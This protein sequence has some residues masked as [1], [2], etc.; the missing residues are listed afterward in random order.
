MD[1]IR[2]P[3]CSKPNP[4]DLAECQYCQARLKPLIID[5]SSE[6]REEPA[7]PPP[8]PEEPS[9][10]AGSEPPED[11]LRNLR[12]GDEPEA[13]RTPAEP[14]ETPDWLS[15]IRGQSEAAS[16]QEEEP[17]DEA[18]EAAQPPSDWLSSMREGVGAEGPEED[19]EDEDVGGAP[20]EDLIHERLAGLGLDRS[21][22]A[23]AERTQES[24]WTSEEDSEGLET[25]DIPGLSFRDEGG[26]AEPDQVPEWLRGLEPEP[27]EET[28]T[29]EPAETSAEP[30]WLPEEEAEVEVPPEGLETRDIPGLSFRDQ[31]E[32]EEEPPEWL[33]GLGERSEE[34]P[35]PSAAGEGPGEPTPTPT[36]PAPAEPEPEAAD[37]PEEELPDWL[38]EPAYEEEP[39]ETYEEAFETRE[40]PGLSFREDDEQESEEE[41]P[42]WLTQLGPP[43]EGSLETFEEPLEEEFP[44]PAI[45]EPAEADEPRAPIEEGLFAEQETAPEA[46]AGLP[47]WMAGD[48][49]AF[50]QIPSEALETREVPGLSFR[51]EADEEERED[52]AIEPGQVPEWL[53]GLGAEEEAEIVE[54]PEAEFPEELP[55]EE[56]EAEEEAPEP[57]W[58]QTSETDR[59]PP[60]AL[61]EGDM[62]DWLRG[63]QAFQEE[64]AAETDEG[65]FTEME[66]PLAAL[67]EE[68][69]EELPEWLAELRAK[70][71]QVPVEAGEDQP[72]PAAEEELPEPAEEAEPVRPGD[73]PEWISDLAPGEKIEATPLGSVEEDIDLAP[74]ELPGWLKAMRPVEAVAPVSPPGEGAGV[75]GVGP[76]AGL[77]GILPAE[78]EITQAG[79]PPTF[80]LRV[81]VTQRQHE[82]INLLQALLKEEAE[83]GPRPTRRVGLIAQHVARW[84]ITALLLAAVLIPALAN[85]RT[86]PLP[87]LVPEETL[88]VGEILGSLPEGAPVLVAFDYQPGTSAELNAT[89]TAVIDHLMLR[90]AP[91]TLVSTS[92]T[93][94]P[95]AER[96]L[97]DPSGV[98]GHGYV[99]GQQYVNLGY[100]PGGSAGLLEFSIDP[101]GV[102]PLPF[103]LQGLENP[104]NVWSAP[105]LQR[106]NALTDFALVMVIADDA[107]IAR[108]W[109]EQVEPRL[110][111]V[112]LVMVTSAGTTPLVRPYYQAGGEGQVDGLVSGLTG[113]VAYERI[114]G[115]SLQARTYWD[116]FSNGL[117]MAEVLIVAGAIVSLGLGLF[118]GRQ[119]ESAEEEAGA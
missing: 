56:P 4:R 111:P 80:S 87:G 106:I 77:Q 103:N 40:V 29:G 3:M 13:E 20:E 85:L 48:E 70:T 84:I 18:E 16:P 104:A 97:S 21:E 42:D 68:Q 64:G 55:I 65:V 101:Q 43:E 44:P 89:A 57:A 52:A 92:P 34:E 63:L 72:P 74:A 114:T 105:P 117:M 37:G 33:K 25:K 8:S 96:L 61:E 10:G 19:F 116:A 75:E 109:I 99:H 17:E 53:E 38:R 58:M 51:D 26:E 62:P 112:P 118:R 91:L 78:P 100:I 31:E 49:E 107:A 27:A 88:A 83:P 82:H 22:E 81:E 108:D 5:S 67:D 113:G 15:R 95:L 35:A 60:V 39:S 76:L 110:D 30:D 41:L 7:E 6:D 79:T 115:R 71:A 24:D 2:C 59:E 32:T 9:T 45:E 102:F 66:E 94:P 69:E 73:L 98:G 36:P 93:G 1:E 14:E 90:G 46:E 23:P 119:P 54:T 11:W 28:P 12:M 86:T 50:D 47:D